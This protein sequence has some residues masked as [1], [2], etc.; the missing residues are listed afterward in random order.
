[1]NHFHRPAALLTAMAR[2]WL[3]LLCANYV[4]DTGAVDLAPLASAA[5][6][7]FVELAAWLGVCLSDVK[8]VPAAGMGNFLGHLHDF[9]RLWTDS[10][11]GIGPKLGLRER[12]T[13]MILTSPRRGASL[14][15]K[16]PNCE[17][18]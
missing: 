1:M 9:T 12:I 4:D 11:V 2:R 17:A 15:G 18:C 8:R 13:Q 10:I 5:Q 14:Q 7:S 3:Y 6:K 16:R